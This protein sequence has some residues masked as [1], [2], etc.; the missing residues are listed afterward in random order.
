MPVRIRTYAAGITK[1]G[2]NAILET[3]TERRSEF[4][5]HLWIVDMVGKAPLKKER[6]MLFQMPIR[7]NVIPI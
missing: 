3:N 2:C 6:E 5:W 7:R 1:E 4:L